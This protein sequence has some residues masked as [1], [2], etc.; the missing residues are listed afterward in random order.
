MQSPL[1]TPARGSGRDPGLDPTPA[2]HLA[3]LES[4]GTFV[5]PI[6]GGADPW[7]IRHGVHY[8]W[9]MSEDELAVAV[10]RSE[11]L[12]G[13]GEKVFEWRP[14]Q[15]GPYRRQVWAPELHRLDGRWYLYVAASDGRN[16]THRMIVLESAADEPTGGFAFKA[17]LFTGDDPAMQTDNRWAI[18]GTVL[19]HR[20]SRYFLWSGWAGERD[21]QWLYITRMENPW[22]LAAPRTRLCANDDFLWERVD[23]TPAG[24]GLNEGPQVLQRN[25]RI[26]VVY[27]AS[28]SWETTYKLGLI[29]LAPGGDP[30]DPQAWHKHPKPVF[31]STDLTWGVGHC[32]FTLSPDGSED[33]IVF[34]AK[35]ETTPGWNRAVHAQPFD[36]DAD[37]RPIFGAPV[38]AGV[39]LT[40]P[41]G[42]EPA[43]ADPI[44]EEVALGRAVLAALVDKPM[45][46]G[47]KLVDVP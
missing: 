26:F 9:C 23:E 20:G 17:E 16:E 39:P 6:A 24:R 12:S 2:G 7:V 42:E 21:E 5:N 31:Q 30:M 36:W 15:D 8:Y 32:S 1:V 18:D 35:L 19:E 37:G 40:L 41:S 46:E 33:W 34:H 27:S 38:G 29:E 13:Q 4:P 28:A 10:Y 14:S 3:N 11:R 43:V 22:T 25:G 44:G 47:V 45:I